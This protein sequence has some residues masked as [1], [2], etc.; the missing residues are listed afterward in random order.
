[1]NAI[2]HSVI[3]VAA[4]LVLGLPSVARAGGPS[5][6]IGAAEDAVRSANPAVAQ[7]QMDLLATAGF[8]AVRITQTWAPGETK[9]SA[10]DLKILD[11]ITA[12]AKKDGIVVYAVA[13]NF[14][15]RTTPLTATDQ[16]DFA[17]Y[18]ASMV[19]AAHLR[20][21]VVGNEPNLNRYWLPQYD[22]AGGDA[23]AAAYESLLAQTYDAVKAVAPTTTIIGGALSP[24]GS[25]DAAGIRPT[26]SPTAFITD[27]GAAYRASGRQLPIMDAL[28]IH[29][30]EDH[31]SIAP[32]D[33]THPN[34]TSIGLADYGKLVSLLGSAFDGTAQAGSSLPI[35]YDEFGVESQIPPAKQPLYGGTEPAVT[36]PVDEATQAAYYRQAIALTFCYPNVQG[37]FLFHAID[38]K[39]LAGWQSGVYYA[40][41][42]PK[43]SLAGV[44]LAIEDAD[45]GVIA[46]C[47]GLALTPTATVTQR[48]AVLAL[49]CS[50]DCTYVAQLYRVPGKLLVSKR[51]RAVA[52]TPTTLPL[53]VPAK[54][55]SYRL[56]LS[57]VAPVNPGRPFLLRM[58]LKPG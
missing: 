42:T 33:G 1:L 46:K 53:R 49:R 58:P 43:T 48:G 37:L 35:Y 39:A 10:G 21:L 5:M 57:A 17:S 31:S 36:Q 32:A 25:D 19:T 26:H 28:S 16:A 4:L 18:A 14:G 11:N 52:G 41:D 55:A 8:R 47:P 56:R 2:R 23:A 54:K 29:P 7:E 34:T 51:G 12:A 9:V 27:M 30:Y 44:R 24:R 38:E 6:A 50:L 20:Y 3:T 22:A 15:S 40:D 45:G 13:M